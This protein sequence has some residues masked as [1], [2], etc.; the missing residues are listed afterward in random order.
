MEL[1]SNIDLDK[2]LT[3]VG[4]KDNKLKALQ[5]ETSETKELIAQIYRMKTKEVETVKKVAQAET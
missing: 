5:A 1:M 2:L 4:Q 3:S